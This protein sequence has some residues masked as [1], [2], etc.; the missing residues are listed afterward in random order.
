MAFSTFGLVVKMQDNPP[1][2][3]KICLVRLPIDMSLGD[4]NN[5]T[6]WSRT[7]RHSLRKSHFC[8]ILSA[9]KS[10]ENK[11]RFEL[12][13]FVLHL[14]GVGKQTKVEKFPHNHFFFLLPFIKTAPSTSVS[15]GAPLLSPRFKPLKKT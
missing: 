9:K 2:M 3:N 1:L 13:L 11:S 14:F 10:S 15:F 5:P 8:I 12:Q 7:K 4:T 6:T